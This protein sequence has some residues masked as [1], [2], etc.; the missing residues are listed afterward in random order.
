MILVTTYIIVN[1]LFWKPYLNTFKPYKFYNNIISLKLS[2]SIFLNNK[3]KKKE[4]LVQTVPSYYWTWAYGFKTVFK[5]NF[6]IFEID[7]IYEKI[8]KK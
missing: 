2:E 6:H 8:N 1:R 5:G 3:K 4:R 7:R